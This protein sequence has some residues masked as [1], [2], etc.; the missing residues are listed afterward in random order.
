[1]PDAS[2][3]ILTRKQKLLL[4]FYKTKQNIYY[5]RL[6]SETRIKSLA[7]LS[8]VHII[9]LAVVIL[10]LYR[11]LTINNISL[12]DSDLYS[13]ALAIAGIIGTSIAILFS[14]STFI[15]QST[16]DLFSTRYL[17]KFVNDG[18]EKLIFWMLVL[19]TILAIVTP[20]FINQ[21]ALVILIAILLIAF[22]FIFILYKQL[23]Q[24]INPE[25]TLT[26][27]AKDA[28]NHLIK[29]N[30]EFK[31]IASIQTKIFN[32][33]A[34]SKKYSL[35]IQYKLNTNWHH[36]VLE[37]TKNLFEIGLRLLAKNEIKT[38]DLTI[39]YILAIYIKHLNL[40]NG[41]FIRKPSSLWGTYSF[42]DEG[43]TTK[44]LEYLQS[45]G[46]RL[47]RE[48]RKENIYALLTIYERLFSN[49]LLVEYADET[50]NSYKGSPLIDLVIA[51]YSGFIE[52]LLETKES[53]WVWE[54][55]KSTTN[56]SNLLLQ[57]TDNHFATSHINKLINDISIACIDLKNEAFYKELVKIYFTQITISWNKYENNRI[58]WDELFKE[59]KKNVLLLSVVSK[60]GLSTS[61]LFIYFNSW[62]EN[63]AIGF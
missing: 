14:F 15:L 47:I 42:D 16:A 46:D 38:F 4:F 26:K 57:K 63:T 45:V 56:I 22:Y 37:D 59:L 29:I 20:I 31:N 10:L 23:R 43:F 48:K 6:Q 35:D 19:F 61:E 39:E 13:I 41:S 52:K 30:N 40:R 44:I 34:E 18:K 8:L 51:Y 1:M 60:V 3:E 62:Q 12:N 32:Y 25:T 7:D 55:I 49:A 27:I 17:N 24:R 2:K 5:F 50:H 9:F 33:Q 28:I 36:R 54:S 11:Y 21:N 53:D 58:Y